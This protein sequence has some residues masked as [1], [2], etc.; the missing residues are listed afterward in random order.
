MSTST[1][2]AVEDRLDPALVRLGAVLVLGAVLAQLDTTIVGVG[3]GAMADGLGATV[4]TVQWVSTGYLLAVA[5]AA[6]LSGW[7]H[8]RYGGKRVWLGSVALFITASALCG[9]A[10]SGPSLIAFRLL[11]GIGGGLMQPVGQALVARHAG[12]RRI[13]RLVGLITVPV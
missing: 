12:P 7:L 8:K 10:W 1:A 4:T 13:G 6:P 5:F 2:R 9:L 11:Q 3:M